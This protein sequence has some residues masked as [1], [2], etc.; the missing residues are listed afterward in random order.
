MAESDGGPALTRKFA[1]N[2][3]NAITNLYLKSH[4]QAVIPVWQTPVAA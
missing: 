4:F 1:C 2:S 3:L